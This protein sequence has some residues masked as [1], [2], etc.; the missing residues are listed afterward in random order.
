MKDIMAR[1]SEA[2]L[3]PP[4]VHSGHTREVYRACRSQICRLAS[5]DAAADCVES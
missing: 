5:S 1:P 2:R 3:F 4:V